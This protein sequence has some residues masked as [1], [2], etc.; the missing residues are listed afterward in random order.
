MT[1]ATDLNVPE[2]EFAFEVN[3]VI[4]TPNKRL[5]DSK[6]QALAV[7]DYEMR[8]A[9]CNADLPGAWDKHA[10]LAVA[11]GCIYHATHIS[12]ITDALR[13]VAE[14]FPLESDLFY[15]KRLLLA[16]YGIPYEGSL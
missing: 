6:W 10:A 9:T 2:L 16:R 13:E 11:S 15:V 14:R 12:H 5:S 8:V 7:L 4:D 3:E 1:N